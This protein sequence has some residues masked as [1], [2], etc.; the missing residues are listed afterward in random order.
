[1]A[2]GR[3]RAAAGYMPVIGF[4]G[5]LMLRG[6]VATLLFFIHLENI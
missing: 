1:V 4:P 3:T 5:M 2:A 6:L